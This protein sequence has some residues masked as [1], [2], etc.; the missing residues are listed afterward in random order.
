MGLINQTN[1]QYY[2][3]TQVLPVSTA[4]PAPYNFTF[5]IP[6]SLGNNATIW[7]PPVPTTSPAD[8][9]E[10]NFFLETSPTDNGPWTIYDGVNQALAG[11]NG[12]VGPNGKG[13]YFNLNN[14]I[15]TFEYPL[16]SPA[17]AYSIDPTYYIRVRLKELN[18]NN[19]AYVTLNDIINNFKVG[20]VGNGKLIPKVDRTDILF[21]A[22]RGLQEFT[23][24]TLKSIKSQELTVPPSLSVV[25]PQD[26]VNYVQCSWIDSSGVKHIIYPTR[27]TINP[28]ETPVQDSN[29]IPVQDTDGKNIVTQSPTE[30]KW[31]TAPDPNIQL[32]QEQNYYGNTYPY[33]NALYGQRYGLDPE[34]A[35]I[36]G[37]FTINERE[38]KFSFS[39]DLAEKLIVL[40]YISDGLAYDGDTRIPKLAEEAI[41]MHIAYS[42]LAGRA[43]Q[44]EYIV[45]RFK[46]D[47]RAALRNA[48]I[49]LSNIKIEEII[50]VM[51][52]KSKWI[53]H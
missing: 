20:Y 9:V 17:L 5:N 24:D 14:N 31:A 22:K 19:Y 11:A 36:N 13:G 6:L 2:T 18:Y 43:G 49:R 7:N 3:G 32:L 53:K 47:R 41:Y 45:Q 52:G 10:T 44:P 42:I 4:F 48:K 26:Y 8:Y 33:F 40:E 46:K 1:A 30:E 21:H 50:E 15:I 51:R 16:Q 12:S 38:G 27:L 28:G 39:S 35:Q 34:T 29:G 37:W 23:Y 25:I